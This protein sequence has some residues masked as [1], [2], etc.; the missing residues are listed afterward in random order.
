MKI[1]VITSAYNAEKT[2]QRTID[3]VLQQSFTEFEYLII[4]HGATDST[5]E[6]IQCNVEKDPRIKKLTIEKNSGFIGVALNFGIAQAQGTYF[7]ILDADDIYYPEFLEKTY[8]AIIKEQGDLALCGYE[9]K[10]MNDKLIYPLHY[11]DAVLTDKESYRNFLSDSLDKSFSY[12]YFDYWWNK[13]YRREYVLEKKVTFESS[14]HVVDA[15]FNQKLYACLPRLV[16]VDYIGIKYTSQNQSSTSMQYQN[17]QYA[18]YLIYVTKWQHLLTSVETTKKQWKKRRDYPMETFKYLKLLKSDLNI[19]ER[20]NQLEVWACA[21]E[22]KQWNR[23]SLSNER[24]L[25]EVEL[26]MELLEEQHGAITIS[27]EDNKLKQYYQLRQEP[28]SEEHFQW[29]LDYLFHE[30]NWFGLSTNYL[31]DSI[32]HA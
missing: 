28:K 20:L 11:P 22:M 15:I 26:V 30:E 1:S 9:I 25:H 27:A 31:I 29:C 32:I 2:L 3:S 18:E 23:S 6:I 17:G 13:L 5:A 10:D 12:T 19:T 7:C 21:E 16:S 8:A 14:Y 24:Q 4:D